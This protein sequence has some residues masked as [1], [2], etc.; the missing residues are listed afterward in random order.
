MLLSIYYTGKGYLSGIALNC[1]GSYIQA[2]SFD[3]S[4]DIRNALIFNPTDIPFLYDFL[5]LQ[6]DLDITLFEVIA[7]EV[8]ENG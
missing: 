3:W 4:M 6:T 2:Y 8:V 7:Y 5:D 1:K